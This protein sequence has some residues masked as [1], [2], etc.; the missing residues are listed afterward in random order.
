M[1][2]WEKLKVLNDCLVKIDLKINFSDLFVIS[3]NI[4]FFLCQSLVNVT[5]AFLFP[6]KQTFVTRV[7]SCVIEP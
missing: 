1:P 3:A 2:K 7:V 4:V 6:P 5:G